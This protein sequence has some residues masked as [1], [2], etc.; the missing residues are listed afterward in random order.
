MQKSRLPAHRHIFLVRLL[1]CCRQKHAGIM[2]LARCV[3]VGCT[4]VWTTPVAY[5]PGCLTYL[6]AG[7]PSVFDDSTGTC[8]FFFVCFTFNQEGWLCREVSS[9]CSKNAK[10]EPCTD[11]DSEDAQARL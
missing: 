6:M 2:R 7:L 3:Y 1:C 5:A 11:L 9:T 4:Q 10:I 8:A